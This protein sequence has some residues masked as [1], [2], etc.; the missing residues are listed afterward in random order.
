MRKVLYIIVL[1]LISY[2]TFGQENES[3]AGDP[4][5]TVID[6]LLRLANTDVPDSTRAIMYSEIASKSGNNDSIIKY[7]N[8]AIRLA[9]PSDSFLLAKN[10]YNIGKA[11]YMLDES[12][13]AIEY[14]EQS[15]EILNAIGL[16]SRAATAY[17][18]IGSCYEDLNNQDS[19]TFY[20]NK[21]L[22]NFIIEKDTVKII[23]A[24]LMTGQVYHN[25]ELHAAAI[26]NYTL[27]LQ[28][29]TQSKDSLETAN[30]YYLI[31]QSMFQQ[32]D[33]LDFKVIEYLRNSI[34]IFESIDTDDT[35]YIQAK[36]LAYNALAEAFIKAARATGQKEYADSCNIY[37][38]K[39]GDYELSNGHYNNYIKAC[40]LRVDYLLFYQ[41]HTEALADFPVNDLKKYHEYLYKVYKLLKNYPKAIEHLE[42]YDEYKFAS[43][44]D[45]TLS[46]MKDSEVERTRM[47]EELKR[48]NAEKLHAAETA[49]Y[50]SHRNFMIVIIIAL[51]AGL[52]LIFRI[53][54]DKYK[55]NKILSDKNQILNSQ[56]AEI[57]AQRD[58][59]E[60]QKNIITEQWNTV[61]EANRKL[62]SSINYA[63]RIQ[64]AAVSTIDEVKAVFPESFVF[65]RPR[66]IVSGDFYRSG[67]C[68]KYPFIVTADCTGH[69]I[70]GAF[71][72]MLGISALKEFMVTE[73]DAENPGTVLDRIREFI[74]TTLT[75]TAKSGYVDDGMDMTI[76][77]FDMEKMEM[78][79][80]IANQTAVIVRKGESIKLK[81]DNMPVGRYISEREHFKSL[82]VKIEKGDMVYT[83]S[84]GIQDQL[85]SGLKHKFLLQNL[86]EVLTSVS[87]K[88]VDSQCEILEKTIQDW[89]GDMLQVDDMT[90]VGIR[91]N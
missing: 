17:I 51:I 75:S 13:K 7:G 40:F 77:C 31:G 78:Y 65:Y 29:A 35:Y 4:N 61:N 23:Y 62:I 43:L 89:R 41:K 21:A 44:N 36:Y 6:S 60:S 66:D 39:I 25:L 54:W 8:L 80:A 73:Y 11:Y 70:P 47:I 12:H 10:N 55:A 72:S 53:F 68:G 49:R 85:G 84:D 76:C 27:A 9:L 32:T 26:E 67:T 42:K 16:K 82:S 57:E 14:F 19:I 28:Y 5:Q 64:R 48:E 59:I 24:Y 58:E 87:D 30:C 2:A 83:F 50:K 34:S 86:I 20:Y 56:K 71:L 18:A 74:K 79:Y 37:L 81:G 1:L 38:D 15:A 69:G 88:T 90:L 52:L 22:K 63:E 46:T 45:S 91:V 33:T 3:N